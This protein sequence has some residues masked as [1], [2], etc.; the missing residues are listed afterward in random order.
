M[1]VNPNRTNKRP[2]DNHDERVWLSIEF[3]EKG[4]WK[5]VYTGETVDIKHLDLFDDKRYDNDLGNTA[6]LYSNSSYVVTPSVE[7]Y[8]AK[9]GAV[10]CTCSLQPVKIRGLPQ[11]MDI[12]RQFVPVESTK[13]NGAFMLKG[14]GEYE[15]HSN[16]QNQQYY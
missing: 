3:S 12:N 16:F 6:V 10:F 15:I 5:D 9:K 11:C 14:Y 2:L 4:T 13:E 1:T 7:K 8:Y